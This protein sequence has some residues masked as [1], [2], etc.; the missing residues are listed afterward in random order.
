MVKLTQ[1]TLRVCAEYCQETEYLEV[2]IKICKAI[3]PVKLATN[4]LQIVCTQTKFPS[5]VCLYCP[6]LSIFCEKYF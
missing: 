1:F 4:I 6:K 2:V 5:W 3:T